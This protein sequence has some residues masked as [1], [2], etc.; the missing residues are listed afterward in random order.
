MILI[1]GLY[2]S[3]KKEERIC[4]WRAKGIHQFQLYF[5]S[6]EK[7]KF[8]RDIFNTLLRVSDTCTD[9][10][11]N[12]SVLLLSF[13]LWSKAHNLKFTILTI[14]SAQYIS[15]N[16]LYMHIVVIKNVLSYKTETLCLLNCNSP[17]CFCYLLYILYKKWVR[18]LTC[19]FF[20]L[21]N[22]KI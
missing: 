21:Q 20:Y 10:C 3:L 8:L 18:Y 1:L 14:L 12:F 16:Y 4:H 9:V 6:L 5:I 13:L 15:V 19:Q 11:Y 22:A 2:L 17:V 7:L